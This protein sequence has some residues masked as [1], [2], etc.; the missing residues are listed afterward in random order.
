MEETMIDPRHVVGS[1]RLA[2]RALLSLPVALA[3]PGV[4]RAQGRPDWPTQPIRVVT[5]S[6]PGSSV[7]VTARVVAEGLT[8]RYPQ[9]FVVD[10]RAG[11]DGIIAGDNF[12]K[13]RPGT[14]LLFAA[15][16]LYTAAPLM[17]APLPYNTSEELIPISSAATDF[18]GFI[19][20]PT[21]PVQSLR[22][23]FELA[24]QRP[25]AMTWAA[26]P[27][28]YLFINAALRGDGL[29]MSYVNYRALTSMLPDV[30]T[31]R[32]DV[33]YVPLT[34]T[35]PL[36]QERKLTLLAVSNTIRS[37]AA[38]DVP[39]AREIGLPQL[40]MDGFPGLFGWRGMP[41]DLRDQLAS[42]VREIVHESSSVERFQRIGLAPRGSTA[43]EFTEELTRVALRYGEAARLYGAKPVE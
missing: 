14:A 26:A 25:G 23:L 30:S 2:R 29:D 36:V 43:A 3:M 34:P 24:R 12:T 6:P 1:G 42:H 10:N 15:A 7:D 17:F 13:S 40:E 39:T 28:A 22:E 11:A 19:V 41:R 31:G 18:L 38:P 21:S 35:M 20:P 4:L 5:P 32:L 33:A 16:G 27:G 8:R 9:P 37:P